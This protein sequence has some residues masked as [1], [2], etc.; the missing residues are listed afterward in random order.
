MEKITKKSKMRAAFSRRK[1]RPVHY[2]VEVVDNIANSGRYGEK[3]FVLM[4][5]RELKSL[6]AADQQLRGEVMR[7]IHMLTEDQAENAGKDSN[8]DKN[9]TQEKKDGNDDQLDTQTQKNNVPVQGEGGYR[10]EDEVEGN[11]LSME[12]TKRNK[13]RQLRMKIENTVNLVRK[14]RDVTN[15]K[16]ARYSIKSHLPCIAVAVSVPICVEIPTVRCAA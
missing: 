13:K 11:Y 4:L 15:A 1:T 7:I 16:M 14:E 5:L 2:A 10:V 6:R 9:D 3:N 12:G 8:E